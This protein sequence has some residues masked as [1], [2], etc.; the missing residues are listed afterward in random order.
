MDAKE[1]AILTSIDASLQ[2]IA[3]SLAFLEQNEGAKARIAEL[4]ARAR[5]TEAAVMRAFYAVKGE[6]F[7]DQEDFENALFAATSTD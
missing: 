1:L 6:K 5:T 7:R 3:N 4:A 2:K